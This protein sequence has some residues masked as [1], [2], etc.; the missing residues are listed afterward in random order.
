MT[1]ALLTRMNEEIDEDQLLELRRE[2]GRRGGLARAASLSAS[3]RS[4]IAK[5]AVKSRWKRRFTPVKTQLNSPYNQQVA[6]S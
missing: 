5:N 2:M 6:E 3:R 1:R 4:E